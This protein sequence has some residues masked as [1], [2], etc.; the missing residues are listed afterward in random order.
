MLVYLEENRKEWEG[1]KVLDLHSG[2]GV[3]GIICSMLGI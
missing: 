2:I 3:C 1:K